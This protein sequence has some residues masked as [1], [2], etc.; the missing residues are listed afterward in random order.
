MQKFAACIAAAALVAWVS[1]E[2]A[3]D[4]PTLIESKLH[5]FE[6]HDVDGVEVETSEMAFG[7]W[8]S[9]MSSTESF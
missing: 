9:I 4:G 5:G 3:G 1:A 8:K 2:T 6:D 7:F